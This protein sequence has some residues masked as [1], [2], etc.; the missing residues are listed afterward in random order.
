MGTPLL[1]GRDFTERDNLH[2]PKVAVVNQEFSKVFFGSKNPVGHSFRVEG[3]A[4][5]ADRIF[6]IVGLVK[7]TKYNEIRETA[8][9]IAFFPIEQDKEASTQRSYVFRVNSGADSLASSL[10]QQ[11]AAVNINLLV[12][13]KLLDLQ[14]HDSVLRERL[15]ANLTSGF[16]FLAACLSTLGLYGVMSYSVT[17]RRNEIGIRMALG[18]GRAEVF[19]LILRDATAML[20][21]GL[22]IGLGGSLLLSRYA[23]SLLFELKGN[24]PVTLALAIALLSLTALGATALPARRAA[25]LEPITALR[26]E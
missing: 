1:A 24:D 23:E 2:A 26:E 13:F 7:N 20:A 6:Q 9:A 10:Q 17:R 15:M 4:G 22:A 12:D 16:G 21:I 25:H 3:L 5:E 18:A 19:T 11:V 14:I 8:Q